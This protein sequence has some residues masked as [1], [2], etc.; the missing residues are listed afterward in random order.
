M[1]CIVIKLKFNTHGTHV[2]IG[3]VKSI[4]LIRWY[5]VTLVSVFQYGLWKFP[6]IEG[7]IKMLRL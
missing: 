1:K 7:D 2:V 5:F 3:T 4:E 6:P